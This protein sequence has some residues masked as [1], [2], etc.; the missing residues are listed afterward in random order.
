MAY[1]FNGRLCGYICAECPEPLANLKVRLYRVDQQRNVAALAVANPK[2]TFAILSDDQVQGKESRL[3]AEAETD[4]EGKF[5]FELGENY[6]GEAFEV[7]VYCGSVPRQKV[8]KNPPKPRQFTI[9]TLQPRYRE[10]EGGFVAVWE[11]CLPYRFWC[12]LLALFDVWTICGQVTIC[13]TEK[14]VAGVK[15][16]AFDADWLADDELGFAFTDAAGK[17]IITYSSVDFRQG[18]WIDVE[19]IGGPDLYFRIEDSGGSP[20]LTETQARGRDPDRENA[21]NCFCVELCVEVDQPPPT[22]YPWFTHVGDFHIY[23]DIDAT[24]GKTSSAAPTGITA[25]GGPNFGFYDGPYGYG[26]KLMGFCPKTHPTGGQPMRYRFLYE[27]PANPGIKEPLMGGRISPVV[28]G[29]RPIMW[30]LFGTGSAWTF[31]TIIIAG[32]GATPPVTPPP[33]PLPPPG[34]SWGS[35][36]SHVIVPDSAGWVTVDQTA[37][38]D[39][40][41]GPLIRFVSTSAVP[42]GAAPGTGAGNPLTDPKS[43]AALKIYFEAE[44]V[45]GP[46]SGAPTL[47]NDLPKILINNWSAVLELNLQQFLAPGANC[48]SGLTNALDIKYTA[49]HELMRSWSVGISSCASSLGGGWSPTPPPLPSGSTPRGGIGT[50]SRNIAAWPSCSYLVTLGATRALTDGE[51]DD[52][53]ASTHL[54]FCK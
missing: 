45:G 20:L 26:L 41:Y 43:G 28:V 34:T 23:T 32:S 33:S 8:H 7:D 15:V 47:G 12:A 4:A 27:H 6:A 35:V 48:C 11:Y 21:G 14:P 29:S 52:T 1:L 42:G 13:D 19:L 30:D 16:R 53:G 46:V 31:Q 49:D 50:D 38:D 18:T 9:T 2:E 3:L 40:F 36:P 39:G 44:P 25:H 51:Y 54:T 22:K 37:L 5:T 24:T 17:F 10:T